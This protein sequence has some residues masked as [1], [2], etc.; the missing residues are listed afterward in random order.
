MSGADAGDARDE[1]HEVD[2]DQNYKPPPEKS[3]EEMLAQD[4]NDES[5]QKYKEA[6]LGKATQEKIILGT[7]SCSSLIF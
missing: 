1:E 6:L 2:V 5:L 4:A 3:L 7:C